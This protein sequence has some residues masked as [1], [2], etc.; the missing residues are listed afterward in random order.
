M[1]SFP[2]KNIAKFGFIILFL[3]MCPVSEST[4]CSSSWSVQECLVNKHSCP[5]TLSRILQ[6]ILFNCFGNPARQSG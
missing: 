1:L 5:R 2:F 3:Q 4:F 6:V